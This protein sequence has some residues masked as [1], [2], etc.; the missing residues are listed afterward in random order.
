MKP[1]RW[2]LEELPGWVR[3]GLLDAAT[4]ERL[5][6][7]VEPQLKARSGLGGTVIGVLG[8]LLIGLGI[9]LLLAHNWDQ[10]SQPV[11][12]LVSVLPLALG[13]GL[14]VWA[15]RHRP[16]S[17][18]WREGS[19][20]FLTLAVGASIALIEQT[21]HLGTRDYQAFLLT[22]ILLALPLVYV[23][24]SSAVAILYWGGLLTWLASARG[25]IELAYWPLLLVSLPHVWLVY[26]VNPQSW[27]A[28]QL[29]WAL[30]LSFC[31]ALVCLLQNW[32]SVLT[33]ILFAG[34]FATFYL[35]HVLWVAGDA[36]LTNLR[37]PL[38]VLGGLGLAGLL[39]L[40]NFAD[41]WRIGSYQNHWASSARIEG[42]WLQDFLLT[43][44]F[45]ASS[46]LLLYRAWSRLLRHER[47]LLLLPAVLG[48]GLLLVSQGVSTVVLALAASAYALACGGTLIQSAL[49]DQDLG[50]LNAGLNL[51]GVVVLLRF[52]DLEFSYVARGVGFVA[53]GAAFLLLNLRLRA[54]VTTRGVS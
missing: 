33:P 45:A 7:H 38:R 20:V 40:F 5:R 54:R 23:L 32:S 51:I 50:R 49:Q 43:V 44:L 28:A 16:D 8:S 41:A 3:S 30:A 17:L 11:R 29:A 27:R 14:V 24:H 13:Q 6:A 25:S 10:W 52:F 1:Q 39:V 18:V 4:A 42:W 19:A 12:A 2:L 47:L 36:P 48:I 26:R 21:Y 22:W 35:K 9:L 53:L 34:L 37:S 31:G 46:T 15:L